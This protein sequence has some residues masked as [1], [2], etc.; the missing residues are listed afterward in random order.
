MLV[1]GGLSDDDVESEWLM[2]HDDGDA[3]DAYDLSSNSFRCMLQNFLLVVLCRQSQLFTSVMLYHLMC[4]LTS[5]S[6]VL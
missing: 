4:W 1:Q 6:G 5:S 2:D 3:D